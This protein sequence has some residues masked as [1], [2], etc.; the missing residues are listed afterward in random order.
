MKEEKAI[1]LIIKEFGEATEKFG[2]FNS[3]HEGIAVIKEEYD[4]LW[5]AIKDKKM[6]VKEYTK[7]A[8]QLAA[9]AF[10]FLVDIC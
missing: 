5:D 10:R 6:G 2:R 1:K 3:A 9:M 8:T 7:E 4:E